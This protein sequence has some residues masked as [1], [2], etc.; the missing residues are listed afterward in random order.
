MWS[1][2][3]CHIDLH[4]FKPLDI[5]CR[6]N[7]NC[8]NCLEE[9]RE[10]GK[11]KGEIVFG[12]SPVLSALEARRRNIYQL[13]IAK[14]KDCKNQRVVAA[15]DR[16]SSMAKV[17]G[18]KIRHITRHELNIF[19]GNRP[20]QG[21]ALDCSPLDFE[22]LFN[23]PID[24]PKRSDIFKQHAVW[25]ALDGVTD[26]QNLGAI[27]R[28][29]FYLGVDGMIV[30]SKKTAP[31][32]AFS[33]KASAGAL[34]YLSINQVQNMPQ[35]LVRCCEEGW[36]V[37]GSDKCDGAKH[38]Q[39][40]KVDGPTMIV[41]GSEGTGLRTAIRLACTGFVYI[42][43]GLPSDLLGNVDSLNVSVAAGILL[44]GLLASHREK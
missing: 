3:H 31:I 20:H 35:F 14:S 40:H 7:L 43:P 34:E 32:N 33:S 28:S 21:L 25:L 17:Q 36:S 5:Y 27:S 39:N 8:S 26:V 10:F 4:T 11:L 30:C 6:T 29:A 41:L 16:A 18:V 38:I 42:S 23:P 12:V 9:S 37:L 24:K 22:I 15:L 1:Y 19:T 2:I 13:F 44:Y